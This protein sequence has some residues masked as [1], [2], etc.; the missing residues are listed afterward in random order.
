MAT[1]IKDLADAITAEIGDGSFSQAFTAERGYVATYDKTD[2]RLRVLVAPGGIESE[3]TSRSSGA[4]R[5]TIDVGIIQRVT[6]DVVAIDGLI[7]LVAEIRAFLDGR[8]L[9][10]LNTISPIGAVQIEP[11]YAP[12]ELRQNRL[13]VSVVRATYYVAG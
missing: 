4:S 7:D 5:M 2:D 13:F 12:D 3:R 1:S 9:E 6:N 8:V 11:L 10:R